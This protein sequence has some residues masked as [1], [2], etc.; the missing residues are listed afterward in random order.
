MDDRVAG[1]IDKTVP[2]T[3][4]AILSTE[5]SPGAFKK[6]KKQ[7]SVRYSSSSQSGDIKPTSD[8]LESSA[9]LKRNQPQMLM[10]N[11]SV[12]RC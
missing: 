12:N 6:N 11:A 9:M 8:T 2:R 10:S 7:K 5:L 4:M 1:K 3:V